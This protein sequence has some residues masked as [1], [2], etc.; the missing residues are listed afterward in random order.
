MR[1][2]ERI[3]IHRRIGGLDQGF[4]EG[5]FEI[6]VQFFARLRKSDLQKLLEVSIL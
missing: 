2:H 5:F 4:G 1:S 6:F 3:Q